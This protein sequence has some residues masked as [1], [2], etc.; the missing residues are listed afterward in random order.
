[1]PAGSCL[2]EGLRHADFQ[3]KGDGQTLVVL[4]GWWMAKAEHLRKYVRVWDQKKISTLLFCPEDPFF[5]FKVCSRKVVWNLKRHL[6]SADANTTNVIFHVFS[7]CFP[8]A[9]HQLFHT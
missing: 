8:Q 9:Y 6:A 1:M 2:T 4:I 5:T 7:N 3:S